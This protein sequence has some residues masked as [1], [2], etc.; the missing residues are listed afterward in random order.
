MLPKDNPNGKRR[1]VG[2][3]HTT[4]C[5]R[6]T[7]GQIILSKLLHQGKQKEEPGVELWT[8][9]P[10]SRQVRR[11]NSPVMDSLDFNSSTTDGLTGLGCFLVLI[12]SQECLQ[13]T[14]QTLIYFIQIIPVTNTYI[15]INIKSA[16]YTNIF[17]FAISVL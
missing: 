6:S 3:R 10:I 13:Y 1:R 2:N 5:Q 12:M 11:R 14:A 8:R 7:W 9:A 16:V 17:T 4:G 15:N